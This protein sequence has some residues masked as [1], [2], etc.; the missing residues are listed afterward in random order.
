MNI[1]GHKKIF[2]TFSG[3]LVLA[4][5]LAI[6]IFG[7]R[8]GIDFKGGTLWQIKFNQTVTES[9]I[10]NVF[11]SDLKV[12]DATI[13]PSDN[14]SYL[15][16]LGNISEKDHQNFKNI[17][18]QKFNGL[19]EL[20]YQSIGPTIGDEL[21][22]NAYWA[23]ILV[24]LG[25]S[26]YVA[27]AFRKVSYPIKSWKYGIITLGTLFHDVIVPA[28]LLAVLGWKLGIEVDSNFVVALLVVMGF[29]VHDTIVVFDRIRENLLNQKGKSEFSEIVN[30]SVNQT[31]AR[32]INT[33]LALILVLLAMFF[34]GPTTLKYFILTILV[35]TTVGTYSSIFVA[36]PLLTIWQKFSKVK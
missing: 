28:G 35:G 32:S 17:L 26:L 33:S 27:Y 14:G 2:L 13:Y 22:H 29:S 15:I 30:T 10:Q 1:I 4:S 25:I 7:F 8:T 16:R 11:I 31:L 36:S 5:I 6:A 9:E 3:I 18:S 21:R 19:D 20:Q 24:L 23:I 12:K 34:F